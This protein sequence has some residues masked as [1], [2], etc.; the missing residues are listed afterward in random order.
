MKVTK[1]ASQPS[2]VTSITGN[3]LVLTCAEGKAHSYT[4]A[5]D[6]HVSYHGQPCKA[7]DVKLGMK[8]RVT[9]AE[10][11]QSMLTGVEL[12]KKAAWCANSHDG[13]VVSLTGN[14]LLM[15][16]EK[17]K[18]H[19]HTLATDAKITCNGKLSKLSDLKAGMKIR[20]TT[21]AETS[22]VTGIEFE[23]PALVAHEASH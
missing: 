20:V 11:D 3:N 19:L 5:A 10:D 21:N 23:Q 7:T 1:R 8:I 13:K 17:G 4:L 22:M 14:I 9:T 18:E 12:E 6:T 16:V 2:E 15:K